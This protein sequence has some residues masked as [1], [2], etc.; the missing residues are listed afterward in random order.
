MHLKCPVLYVF[1][2][3]KESDG[4]E[5]VQHAGVADLLPELRVGL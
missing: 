4:D 2:A 5:A 1:G 3:D